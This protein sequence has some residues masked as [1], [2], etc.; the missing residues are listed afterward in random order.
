L[1]VNVDVAMVWWLIPSTKVGFDQGRIY[2]FSLLGRKRKK[3]P[4]RR[5]WQYKSWCRQHWWHQSSPSNT[6]LCILLLDCLDP[7]LHCNSRRQSYVVNR[8]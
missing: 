6:L 5:K 3:K 4:C 1:D 2:C 8:Q 7:A